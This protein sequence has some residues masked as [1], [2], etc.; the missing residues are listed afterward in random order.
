MQQAVAR[1]L[2]SID[3]RL[4]GVDDMPKLTFTQNLVAEVLRMY[5]SEWLMT[6]TAR[7][8]DRLPSGLLVRRG[9]QV[10]ISSYALGRNA[11]HFLDPEQFDPD[12]FVGSP[13]W[14]RGA[15]IPFGAGPRGCIGEFFARL[16]L[17][18]SLALIV[19]RYR[20]EAVAD[21][22]PAVVSENLFTLQPPDGQSVFRFRR[23]ETA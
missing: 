14:P 20:I 19:R 11:R 22:Y 12:R 8:D 4:P 5:P 16:Q 23:R 7:A 2:E 9:R 13:S 1:E 3:A 15:Y 17:T 6:R 21:D 10:M 18:L